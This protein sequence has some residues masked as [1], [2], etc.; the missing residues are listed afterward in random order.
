MADIT[1]TAVAVPSPHR[2]GAAGAAPTRTERQTRIHAALERVANPERVY[3]VTVG[4]GVAA[5]LAFGA[6]SKFVPD[7]VDL[8][9][10]ATGS[11][12]QTT[13]FVVIVSLVI[14]AVWAAI[15]VLGSVRGPARAWAVRHLTHDAKW[16]LGAGLWFVF[17][18]FSTAKTGLL[19]PP[20]FDA[21]QQ[22]L[23]SLWAER[24]I[25]AES[26]GSSLL[27]LAVGF[28]VGLVAGLATGVTIGWFQ[29]ANYW[30]H[31]ILIFI[32]PVPSL[33]WV[34]IVFVL[35]P[36]TY[37][38][39]VFMIALSVWFPITVLTRAGILSVPR[40]YYDV[41][42]TLGA[43]GWFLVARI[44]LPAALPSIFTGAFMALGASF[45]SLT[46]AE[47]FGVNAGL[48]W[49]LNYMKGFGNYPGLYAGIVVL[50]LVC[51]AALTLLFRFRNFVLRWEKELTRW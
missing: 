38:G 31:P 44:S 36:S 40:S 25:L 19:A 43:K 50:V 47:N 46:V 32:G 30:V 20:Y 29:A 27:L 48:G 51:G 12:E 17:W 49:Y 41:A 34:P 4:A 13:G 26:L 15:W 33:A 6:I 16:V 8:P 18:E 39:A 7:N 21:P 37:S 9:M 5:W 1:Q 45:V 28:A 11:I 3:P 23:T 24:G 14:A 42:Q 35:F 10:A 2:A 22:I